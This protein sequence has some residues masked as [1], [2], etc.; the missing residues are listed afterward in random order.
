MELIANLRCNLHHG[1]ANWR[2]YRYPSPVWV[3]GSNM[4]QLALNASFVPN[5]NP[6]RKYRGS[7]VTWFEPQVNENIVY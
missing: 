3:K 2:R 7:W 1:N 5:P 4:H 6:M